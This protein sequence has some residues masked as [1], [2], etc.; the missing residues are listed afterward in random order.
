M[1]SLGHLAIAIGRADLRGCRFGWRLKCRD[2]K[3]CPETFK[4]EMNFENKMEKN[5]CF[6][7]K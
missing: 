3:H 5:N 7:L 1:L 6:T 2:S 4:I